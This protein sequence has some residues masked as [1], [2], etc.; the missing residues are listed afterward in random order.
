MTNR[1]NFGLEAM[2]QLAAW[3]MVGGLYGA[4]ITAIIIYLYLS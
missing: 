4:G 3:A 1:D 2:R